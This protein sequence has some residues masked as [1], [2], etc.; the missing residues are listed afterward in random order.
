MLVKF[1][2]DKKEDWEDYLDCCTFSYNTSKHESS[3]FTP[4]QVMYCRRAVLPVDLKLSCNL[5]NPHI[6]DKEF[7]KVLKYNEMMLQAVKENIL[8][9]QSRQKKHSNP[10]VFSTGSLVLM[11][12]CKR[13]KRARGKMDHKWLGPYEIIRVKGKGLYSIENVEDKKVIQKVHG[14]C[15]KQYHPSDDKVS[16]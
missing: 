3:K 4:F 1:V 6:D 14:T 11:K 10:E 13:K 16:C 2:K 15:L 5:N 9:A 8:E 12:D 7:D